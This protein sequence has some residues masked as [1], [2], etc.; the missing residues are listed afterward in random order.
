MLSHFTKYLFKLTNPLKIV[1]SRKSNLNVQD[2]F[3]RW[4]QLINPRK[5]IINK[6]NKPKIIAGHQQPNFGRN[7]YLG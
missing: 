1:G 3:S 6:A 5:F 2:S 4:L 7:S